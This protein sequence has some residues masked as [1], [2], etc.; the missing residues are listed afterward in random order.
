[1]PEKPPRNSLADAAPGPLS[2]LAAAVGGQR[3]D[4]VGGQV[5]PAEHRKHSGR[6]SGGRGVDRADAR[7]GMRR[8]RHHRVGLA[9]EVDVVGV[10]PEAPDQPRVL[11]P[12]HRLT[13]R[14]GLGDDR[15]AHGRTSSRATPRRSISN[16][17]P[18]MGGRL[19]NQRTPWMAAGPATRRISSS[20]SAWI[21]CAV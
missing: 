21:G 11:E 1:M 4:A 18:W 3:P 2:A 10:A 13:D 5:L 6:S 16:S 14:E 15:L 12:P 20:T 8:A 7:V 17:S 9:R 19:G